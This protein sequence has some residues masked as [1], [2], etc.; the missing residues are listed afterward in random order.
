MEKREA[1]GAY[2][3]DQ[4]TIQILEPVALEQGWLPERIHKGGIANAVRSLSVMRSPEFLVVDLSQSDDPLADIGALA[5]VC[6]PGT[7]VLAV[8]SRNDVQL[9]RDLLASGIH[10]YLL[11][12]ING[13]DLRATIA[14]ALSARAEPDVPASQPLTKKSVAVIGVRGGVGA[15]GLASGL[16]W[17]LADDFSIDVGLLDLD[18]NFGTNALVFDLEP[19]RGLSDA[20]E[21][22]NRV[23]S[24]FIERAMLKVSDHLSV[25][26]SEA[27]L[28]DPMAPDSAALMHLQESLGEHFD[29]VLI[30]LPRTMASS[31]PGLL[32]T[33]SDVVLVSELSLAATRD[34]IRMM[35]LLKNHAPQARVHLVANKVPPLA[36]QEVSQKD[37]EA[38]VEH[39][40]DLLIPADPKSMLAASKQGK[41]LPQALPS[42]KPVQMMRNLAQT[43]AGDEAQAESKS[44]WSKLIRKAP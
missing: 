2:L 4:E 31:Y 19:G 6:E 3:C 1:F 30:D 10:D 21:N 28:G 22:P 42:S 26:G 27:P 8:G 33:I 20:L 9:Y 17:I 40:I 29:L 16:A 35:G 23:D 11:K 25:L 5:D 18:L 7:L 41:P 34:T 24:L 13:D 37:F 32:S 12:P 43:L 38:S 39:G 44:F 14:M 36:Q 15:S